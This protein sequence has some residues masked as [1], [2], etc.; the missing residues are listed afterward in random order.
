M[1]YT[2]E[3]RQE[4]RKLAAEKLSQQL[5]SL[6][7]KGYTLEVVTTSTNVASIRVHVD[8]KHASEIVSK[9]IRHSYPYQ[10]STRVKP[11]NMDDY[12]EIEIDHIKLDMHTGEYRGYE[13]DIRYKPK[14]FTSFSVRVKVQPSF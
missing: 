9:N 1:K 14:Y 5:E 6:N 8:N 4:V 11:E 3:Q 13:E 7:V 2:V 10:D 12:T